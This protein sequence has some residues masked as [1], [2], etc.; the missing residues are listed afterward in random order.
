MIG[1]VLFGDGKACR[2]GCHIQGGSHLVCAAAKLFIAALVAVPGGFLV[3][4]LF[5]AGQESV[6]G[7]IFAGLQNQA[8]Q[9]LAQKLQV[10]VVGI[11]GADGGAVAAEGF[12]VAAVELQ[13]FGNDILHGNGNFVA[14]VG[15]L[16]L[17]PGVLQGEGI[18]AGAGGDFAGGGV[19]HGL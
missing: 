13:L 2:H 11:D 10:F 4:V 5:R 1:G 12:R 8:V 9:L 3:A 19:L 15:G 7:E 18:A 6:K 16:Q 17:K 14:V